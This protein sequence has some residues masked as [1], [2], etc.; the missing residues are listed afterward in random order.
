MRLFAALELSA[1]AR[2]G[3]SEAFARLRSLA[4][5]A[6]W[7][8]A[9]SMHLTLHFFG[10]I[11]DDL[12]DRFSPVFDDPS[13]QVPAMP[14]RFG[15]AGFFPGS[16]TPKVLWMGIA[17]GVEPMR[18]F[19]SQ[20]TGKLEA[21][22]TGTGPLQTWTPDA[23]GFSPHITVARAGTVPLSRQ[24]AVEVKP[25]AEEFT[26][27]RCVL[28]QSLLGAG[29]ARYVPQKTIQFRGDDK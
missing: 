15:P 2:A 14:V 18:A 27:R 23:R 19:W 16:G 4:P 7:V 12:V 13:L 22:R 10:E 21:L 20:L 8:S 5:K 1:E 26:V 24:W 25:P 17:A 3:I 9:E 11:P 28:F 6:R 29:G